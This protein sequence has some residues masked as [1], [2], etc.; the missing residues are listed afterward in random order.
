MLEQYSKA[1]QETAKELRV[2]D[3]AFFKLV[4]EKEDVC[5]EILRTLLDMPNLVVVNVTAQSLVQSFHR[6]IY[7]DAL[8]K[9][10]DGTLCNIEMQKGESE[11]DIRRTRFHAAAITSKFTPKGTDFSNLPKVTILYITEYDSLNNNRAVTHVTRCAETDNGF[12][13]VNDGEDI[14]FANTCVDDGS[15]K[16]ELLQ[17]LLRR[18]S[19]YD[20]KFPAISN[21]VKYF[22]KTEGGNNQMAMTY[23]ELMKVI[24]D[25]GIAE[26]FSEGI[27]EGIAKGETKGRSEEIF[28]SVE[29]GDYSVER[30][31]EK[32][33]LS[34][35]EF[36]KKM[37]EAGYKVP[38]LAQKYKILALNQIG[39]GRFYVCAPWARSN[40]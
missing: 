28:S 38:A 29:E 9:L 34:V 7:L 14:V 19:F 5:Q 39:W 12:M 24:K 25:D 4:A 33:K 26:G 32:L 23:K 15:N 11:D 21:A 31:A 35:D 20:E 36:I 6:E 27:A 37:E 30:G 8:C 2:I 16:A 22:K 13:P 3:D 18:D 10:E 1:I 17:L 40:G